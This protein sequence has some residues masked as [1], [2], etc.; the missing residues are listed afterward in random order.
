MGEPDTAWTARIEVK[1]AQSDAPYFHQRAAQFRQLGALA[2]DD[3]V[4]REMSALAAA[5]EAKASE[6]EGRR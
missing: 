4:R 1:P 2:S 3:S 5:Y 6:L